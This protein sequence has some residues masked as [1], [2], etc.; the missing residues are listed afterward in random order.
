M[1]DFPT[2][3][4][5]WEIFDHISVYTYVHLEIL[6]LT[7]P[8]ITYVVNQGILINPI[9]QYTRDFLHLVATCGL[10]GPGSD[11]AQSPWPVNMPIHQKL[12][13]DEADFPLRDQSAWV[14]IGHRFGKFTIENYYIWI[15][16]NCQNLWICQSINL[17]KSSFHRV[18]W[19]GS[20][21]ILLKVQCQSC[22][23]KRIVNIWSNWSK[24]GASFCVAMWALW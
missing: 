9:K 20:R 21:K 17:K 18:G 2:S 4:K 24:F 1:R 14:Q 15:L 23:T 13:G 12:K 7:C 19:G 16:T 10:W 8:D 22:Q 11:D 5:F 6:R 3:N